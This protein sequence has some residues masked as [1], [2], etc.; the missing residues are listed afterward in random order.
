MN[1]LVKESASFMFQLITESDMSSLRP[2]EMK[3]RLQS[4]IG[5]WTGD[6]LERLRTVQ[7][8]GFELTDTDLAISTLYEKQYNPDMVY[9]D[10]NGNI[11]IPSSQRES[12][13][14][15]ITTEG[16]ALQNILDRTT[17]YKGRS[18]I[19]PEQPELAGFDSDGADLAATN[20]FKVKDTYTGTQERFRLQ[21]SG[22][23]FWAE[24]YNTVTGEW[25]KVGN[26]VK[27]SEAYEKAMNTAMADEEEKKR[28][29]QIMQ[30]SNSF[31]GI[32]EQI[33]W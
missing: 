1:A 3:K 27:L 2:D 18:V 31:S 16:K 14:R 17:E 9:R 10:E 15:S 26:M 6:G 20:S 4:W 13:M 5:A 7:R 25:F 30:T 22:K 12:F 8:K 33:M 11:H 23:D 19:I 24:K 29:Q 21:S 28:Q 32:P